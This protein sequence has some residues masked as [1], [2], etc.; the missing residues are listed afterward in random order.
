[1]VVSPLLP[2]NERWVHNRGLFTRTGAVSR[3]VQY[4][5]QEQEA[6]K[7]GI[8]CLTSSLIQDCVCNSTSSFGIYFS[9]IVYVRDRAWF[10]RLYGEII[11]EL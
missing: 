11:P 1:M 4:R 2:V 7:S 9:A 10:V 6:T 8:F 3:T 5:S